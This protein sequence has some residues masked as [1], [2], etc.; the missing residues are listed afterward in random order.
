MPGREQTDVA[1]NF[2]GFIQ[3]HWG[4]FRHSISDST[5]VS[6]LALA[7]SFSD[8]THHSTHDVSSWLRRDLI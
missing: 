3:S 4:D 1:E 5:I 2:R 8:S 6:F 7:S